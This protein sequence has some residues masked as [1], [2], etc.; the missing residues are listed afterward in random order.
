MAKVKKIS[1][2]AFESVVKENFENTVTKEWFGIP[3]TITKTISFEEVVNFVAEVADNCFLSD[4]RYIPEAM[5][6][7][8]DCGVVR[9]YT[10]I[11]LP[12]N[13]SSAY[14][15]VMRSGIIDFI[16]P[17]IN[18]NQYNDIIIAIRDKIEYACDTNVTEF[19]NSLTGMMESMTDLQEKT[20][21]LF[22][23]ISPDE[24]QTLLAAFGD[25]KAVENKVVDAYIDKQKVELQIVGDQ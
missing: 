9:H 20:K 24:I 16:M 3:V 11:N 5:Q 18:S 1:I 21:E 12:A 7:L 13:L 8:I 25:D 4:G 19:R 14:E 17:E 15:L 10:N 6:A 22:G 23:K 2:N